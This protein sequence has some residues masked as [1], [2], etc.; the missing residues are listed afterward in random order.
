MVNYADEDF[1]REVTEGVD[2]DAFG[3]GYAPHSLDRDTD[4]NNGQWFAL[5]VRDK[6]TWTAGLGWLIWDGQRWAPDNTLMRERLVNNMTDVLWW[7]V[8]ETSDKHKDD[9]IKRARRLESAQGRANCL[10]FAKT[11]LARKTSDFDRNGDLFNCENGTLDTRTGELR[12]HDPTDLITRIS[13]VTYDPQA[14]DPAWDGFLATAMPDP[15]VR[16]V[17]QRFMGS[18][19]AAENGDKAFL[20]PHGPT[21]TGKST[22]TEPIAKVLGDVGEGGYAASWEAQ[23]VQSARNVNRGEKLA[24]ARAARLVVVGELTKGSYFDDS[25]MKRIT[26]GD[27]LD[28]KAL[29]R[30]SFSFRPE[31]HVVMHSNYVPKTSD[32]ALLGR[33]KILPFPHVFENR[34]PRTKTYLETNLQAQRAILRWLVDGCRAWR[35]S[36]LGEMPWLNEILRQHQRESSPVLAFLDE[37]TNRSDVEAEWIDVKKCWDLYFLT[38]APLAGERRPLKK[39]DFE[40]ALQD[41]GYE[42]RRIM[43]GGKKLTVWMGLKSQDFDQGL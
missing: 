5:G 13:P 28:A 12:P 19:L 33:M 4:R 30:D 18:C 31:F 36:G 35:E 3:R 20:V 26:G 2:V 42:K 34:D 40:G 10:S 39:T 21:N 37:Y 17:F 9:V 11:E 1:R 27:T 14:E 38:W 23:V 22:A 41:L 29:Y 43:R 16:L 24:K 25:F 32:P 6:L 15:Q 7:R 8:P